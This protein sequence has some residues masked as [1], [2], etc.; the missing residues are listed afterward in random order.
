VTPT[1][2]GLA[3][4]TLLGLAFVGALAWRDAHTSRPVALY[5][6]DFYWQVHVD[7]RP[8]PSRS[9]RI[10]RA[11]LTYEGPGEARDVRYRIELPGRADPIL[12][13]VLDRPLTAGAAADGPWALVPKAPTS[14]Q[15]A[16]AVMSWNQVPGGGPRA[17]EGISIEVPLVAGGA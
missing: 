6:R 4:G 17:G 1:V 7:V 15:T 13:G 14:W 5:G 10:V 11:V 9:D 8:A 3:L 12:G 2:R 16:T